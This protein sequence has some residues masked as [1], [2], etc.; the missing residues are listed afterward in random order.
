MPMKVSFTLSTAIILLVA[1]STL[2]AQKKDSLLKSKRAI[3]STL[4]G[5][6]LK[7]IDGK[8]PLYYSDGSELRAKT[9]QKLFHSCIEYYET[10]FP[11]AKFNINIYVLNKADWEKPHLGYPYGMP[12]YNPDNGVLAIGAEKNALRRLTGLPDDPIKSDTV[13]STFDFQ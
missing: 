6:H 4:A 3:D 7:L 5:E 8:P 10:I 1:T 13:L 11:G 9:L 12:F 2:R